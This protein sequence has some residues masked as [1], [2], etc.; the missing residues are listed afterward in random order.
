MAISA[1][2]S[3]GLAHPADIG[4]PGR[5]AT[6]EYA[7]SQRAA[8]AVFLRDF[9]R[10]DSPPRR[11]YPSHEERSHQYNGGFSFLGHR[12]GQ[13]F[14]HGMGGVTP[15]PQSQNGSLRRPPPCFG[16]AAEV[17]PRSPHVRPDRQW[18]RTILSQSRN[19]L[20]NGEDTLRISVAGAPARE[21]SRGTSAPRTLRIPPSE[22]GDERGETRPR[23]FP[24]LLDDRGARIRTRQYTRDLSRNTSARGY[25]YPRD[26]FRFFASARGSATTRRD[27]RVHENAFLP[28]LA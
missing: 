28:C 20:P 25:P 13:N 14:A 21:G 3:R 16:V 19:V 12:K 1:L 11:P 4:G 5:S 9:P 22:N 26:G 15:N 8:S 17:T 10:P 6:I 2:R 23:A 27:A 18:L 24:F 7:R